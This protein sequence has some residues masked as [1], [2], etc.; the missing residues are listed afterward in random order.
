MNPAAP[1]TS[2]YAHEVQRLGLVL[3]LRDPWLLS[4]LHAFGI[5]E[6]TA[7]L[8]RWLPMIEV[9]WIDGLTPPER[10]RIISL[11]R[12]ERLRLDTEAQR[13]LDG[14]LDECPP[15]PLLRAARRVRC[16]Q[17]HARTEP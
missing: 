11:I 2:G 5:R 7:Y 14:W 10:T 15:A 1:D 4:A 16:A 8:V 17:F 9:G 12:T 6:S 3:G 13:L